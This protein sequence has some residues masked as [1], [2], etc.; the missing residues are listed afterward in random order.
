MDDFGCFSP[1]TVSFF[2]WW[3]HF[4]QRTSYKRLSKRPRDNF[5][6]F[7]AARTL[8]FYDVTH[9]T[10]HHLYMPTD[11]KKNR[12]R[13]KNSP[14]FIAR[15]NGTPIFRKIYFQKSQIS[16]QKNV[17]EKSGIFFDL[18]NQSKIGSQLLV[19]RQK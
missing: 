14:D 2:A 6:V 12:P 15:I 13:K 11:L 10:I 18:S 3:T 16:R 19:Y 17:E 8:I 7:L 5:E 9:V 1:K 4:R